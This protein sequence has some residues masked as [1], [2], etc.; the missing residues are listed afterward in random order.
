MACFSTPQSSLR[1]I[2]V[3]FSSLT[4]GDLSPLHLSRCIY[5]S[6]TVL[7]FFPVLRHTTNNDHE[8]AQRF[9]G[10]TQKQIGL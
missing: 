3:F 2:G 6:A 9:R 5:I 8:P 10:D 4:A 7:Y 1:G